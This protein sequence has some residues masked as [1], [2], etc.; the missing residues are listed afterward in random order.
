MVGTPPVS[1]DYAPVEQARNVKMVAMNRFALLSAV[2]MVALTPAATLAQGASPRPSG[3]QDTAVQPT[4]EQTVEIRAPGKTNQEWWPDRLDLTP[5]RQQETESNPYGEKFDYAKEFN[6]LDLAAVKQEINTVLTSSQPWWP[7]DYGNYGPFFIRMAWHGAGTYRQA[8]GRGGAQQRFEPLNS[9]PDN[10]N[11]DKARRLLWPIKQKYGRKI[12]WGDLME[13]TGNVAL[14][15]MGFKTIGFAGGRRDEWEADNTYW[16]PEHTFL[17]DERHAGPGLISKPLAASQI[18]L[19]YVNPEGPNGDPNPLDAAKEIRSTFGNMGMNDEETVALIA[20]GHTFGKSHGAHPA[21]DCQGPAPTGAGV[22]QQG[23]GWKSKCGIGSGD[24]T[25]GAGPEGAWSTSPIKFTTQYLENLFDNDWVL[26]KS[27]AGAKQW[28]PQVVKPDEMTPDAHDPS[29]SHPLMMFTTDLSLKFDPAYR[30]I[31]LRFKDHPE[32][33]SD[34]FAK[35]WFKL[36]HRDMGPRSGYLG[37]DVPK[38]AFI[39]QDPL[40]PAPRNTINAADLTHLKASILGAGISGP[41]LVRTAW[42]SAASYRKTDMRGGANGAR[43]RLE[44]QVHWEANSPAELATVLQRLTAI[45]TEFNGTRTAGA[46]VSLTD[47]IVLGGD[48]AIEQAAQKGGVPITVPFVPGRVDASQEQTDVKGYTAMEPAADGFRNFYSVE[49]GMTPAA[50]LVERAYLLDL[51]VPE[52]T[53]LVGGMR[54]LNANAGQSPDGVFTDRPGTLSNDFF[55]NLLDMGTTWSKSTKA[56]GI[57]EGA[58]RVSGKMRWT[59]TPVDLA[60]GSNSELRAV[61]EVYASSDAREK[62]VKDFVVAWNKVM[63]DDRQPS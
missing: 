8:D 4:G 33:F 20:G 31:S 61:S 17:A 25:S 18:G 60:F 55:V 51:T 21:A 23:L 9:W 57:Y 28:K 43:V 37:P 24:D 19:I 14:E 40:P 7:A 29:K 11:L 53:V 38:E 49:S 22:E 13:L 44:P 54:A 10:V 52:M 32:E 63:N 35:A 45:Q 26:T 6:S 36:I 42:A 2:A 27:P 12:S 16:G 3:A 41:A 58:D 46:K 56:D 48:A 50:S 15:S 30:T 47:L 62:F 1:Q 59:A 34:A 39:W 5:L